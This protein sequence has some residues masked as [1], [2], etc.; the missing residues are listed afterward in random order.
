[1]LLTKVF[2]SSGDPERRMKA[3]TVT[4]LT[5]AIGVLLL[6]AL[7]LYSAFSEVVDN[8]ARSAA[9]ENATTLSSTTTAST[10]RINLISND[11]DALNGRSAVLDQMIKD[12][13]GVAA[14]AALENSTGLASLSTTVTD[15]SGQI[16]RV[17][18][19]LDSLNIAAKVLEVQIRAADSEARSASVDASSA[20]I[21]LS[22]SLTGLT[23]QAVL[24]SHDVD[25]LKFDSATLE[26][27]MRDV[28]QEL[29]ALDSDFR[30]LKQRFDQRR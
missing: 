20:V 4:S 8:K 5:G 19:E 12:M 25:A 14:S 17:S 27:R 22:T 29:D 21:T 7:F 24:V 10:G 3:L 13:E 28:Q 23:E 1:M 18:G 2:G 11:V 30:A 26:D 6:L 15:Q 16:N 9:L